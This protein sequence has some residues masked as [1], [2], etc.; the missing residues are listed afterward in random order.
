MESLIS[1]GPRNLELV[2]KN[3]IRKELKI[4][5]SDQS[6]NTGIRQKYK[7]NKENRRVQPRKGQKG[8]YNNGNN[9]IR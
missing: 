2:Q 5:N 1:T 4:N 7:T 8:Y 3:Y 6:Q 9:N